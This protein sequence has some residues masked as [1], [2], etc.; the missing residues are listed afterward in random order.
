MIKEKLSHQ[1]KSV[2]QRNQY[3]SRSITVVNA[4]KIIFPLCE[5]I[6]QSVNVMLPSVAANLQVT[7]SKVN[8][9]V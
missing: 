9:S 6:G 3:A 4:W 2:C 7:I 5:V 1:G 8:I